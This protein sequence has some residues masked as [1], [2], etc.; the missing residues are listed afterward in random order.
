MR[1]RDI[2]QVTKEHY[3]KVTIH[4][5]QIGEE[6]LHGLDSVQQLESPYNGQS[7]TISATLGQ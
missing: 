2:L 7:G 6:F 3:I 1:C 4:F 5:L